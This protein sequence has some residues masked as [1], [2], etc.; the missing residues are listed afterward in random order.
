MLRSHEED[1]MPER[2]QPTFDPDSAARAVVDHL[3][4]VV[5]PQIDIQDLE[6]EP[7]SKGE[8]PRLDLADLEKEDEKAR[9][10]VAEFEKQFQKLPPG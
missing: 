5:T 7:K 1:A 10:A 3:P 8:E 4:E 2:Q 6:H 9:D